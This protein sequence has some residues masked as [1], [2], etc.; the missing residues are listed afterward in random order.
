M[1]QSESVEYDI[2]NLTRIISKL[3]L[4]NQIKKSNGMNRNSFR[5]IQQDNDAKKAD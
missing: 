1:S 4:I 2:E 3:K 5:L